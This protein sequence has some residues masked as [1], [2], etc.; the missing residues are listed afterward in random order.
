MT[1]KLELS[2]VRP[3]ACSDASPSLVEAVKQW[4]TSA[5]DADPEEMLRELNKTV[6][7]QVLEAE[8]DHHL[9]YVK[10]DSVGDGSGNIRNGTRSKTV[11]TIVGDVTVDVPRDRNGSFQPAVVRPYQRRLSGFDDM[12]ISLYGKGLTTGEIRSHL[13]EIY[14]T[15][16]SA[17]LVSEITD[18]VLGEFDQWQTVNGHG[19][20][21]AGGH[22]DSPGTATGIPR[23]RPP[24]FPASA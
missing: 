1:K 8:M 24:G 17:E 21:P 18:R 5:R 12:V 16:V 3:E 23:G 6:I 19:E 4:V 10:H 15:S 13:D 2:E 11:K 14:D 22:L 7:E 9:G 20:F